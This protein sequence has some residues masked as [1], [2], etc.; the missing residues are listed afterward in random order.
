M[1]ADQGSAHRPWNTVQFLRLLRTAR[2]A[3]LM[4]PALRIIG[5]VISRLRR[6]RRSRQQSQSPV[7]RRHCCAAIKVDRFMKVILPSL[8]QLRWFLFLS[9]S[10]LSSSLSL[11]LALADDEDDGATAF[12]TARRFQASLLHRRFLRP[13]E[14]HGSGHTR[15]THDSLTA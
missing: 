13:C 3:T 6:R 2:P 10:L 11:S 5:I 12:V 9:F 8:R 7:R 15:R 1:T 14:M 4:P